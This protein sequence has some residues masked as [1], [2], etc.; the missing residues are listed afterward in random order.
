[1]MNLKTVSAAIQSSPSGLSLSDLKPAGFGRWNSWYWKRR[2]GPGKIIKQGRD[3][4]CLVCSRAQ[5]AGSTSICI[6][7]LKT[8]RTKYNWASLCPIFAGVM[9]RGQKQTFGT[10]IKPRA[11]TN[12]SRN[13]PRVWSPAG[14]RY[15][16]E[17]K[18]FRRGRN[19]QTP[20]PPR[21]TTIEK[22][23]VTDDSR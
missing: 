13:C 12:E 4:P 19:G 2:T 8:I 23:K 11:W 1:M 9:Y 3:L 6:H 7:D 14:C 17:R 15:D 16:R 21:R 18:R 20:H 10:R 5:T 22:A